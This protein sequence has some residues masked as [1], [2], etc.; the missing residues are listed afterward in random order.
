[1]LAAALTPM[2]FALLGWEMRVA[3]AG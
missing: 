1:V 2:V 3:G